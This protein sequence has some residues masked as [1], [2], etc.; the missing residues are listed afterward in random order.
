MIEGNLAE[1]QTARFFRRLS[2]TICS[3]CRRPMLFKHKASRELPSQS[4]P[5]PKL[6]ASLY[7][8]KS[9]S[10]PA[11]AKKIS[12]DRQDTSTSRTAFSFDEKA[13]FDGWAILDPARPQAAHSLNRKTILQFSYT[14]TAKA[15]RKCR[16]TLAKTPIID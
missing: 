16:K 3:K 13:V 15:A 7:A 4:I 10:I 11:P 2:V 6:W 1:K 9:V 5:V 8:A 12:F 14:E